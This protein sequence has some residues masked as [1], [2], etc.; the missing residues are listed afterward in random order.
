MWLSLFKMV[1]S[2][3]PILFSVYKLSTFNP[4]LNRAQKWSKEKK[5]ASLEA[6]ARIYSR[7]NLPKEKRPTSDEV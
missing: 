1:N 5:L 6:S 2:F 3:Y 4:N 7:P